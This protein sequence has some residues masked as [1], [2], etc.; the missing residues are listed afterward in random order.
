MSSTTSCQPTILRITSTASP[1]PSTRCWP[2]VSP[3]S[4][5]SSGNWDDLSLRLPCSPERMKPCGTYQSCQPKKT[6]KSSFSYFFL[7]YRSGKVET[8]QLSHQTAIGADNP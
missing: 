5:C 4:I 2:S 8:Y 1:Q 7:L 6:R 3:R